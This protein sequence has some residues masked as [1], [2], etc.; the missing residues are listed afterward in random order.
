MIHSQGE[1]IF[2]LEGADER[3]LKLSHCSFSRH[4]PDPEVSKL[5]GDPGVGL[6]CPVLGTYG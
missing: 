1:W 5:N 2:G 4:E 6:R 3:G